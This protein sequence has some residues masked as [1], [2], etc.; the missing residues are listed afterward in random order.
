M[1]KILFVIG[2]VLLLVVG[3]LFFGCG[4]YYKTN[5]VINNSD[6]EVTFTFSRF[7]ETSYTL[8]PHTSDYYSTKPFIKTYSAKPPRVSYTTD[9]DNETVT[10]Y[11]TTA[12]PIKISNDLDR[13]ILVTAQGC[14]DNEPITVLA[15]DEFTGI[16]YTNKPEFSG[17][18]V[19]DRFPISFSTNGSS[20]IAHW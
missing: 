12:K 1:R 19:V 7:P 11:N 17:F 20:V 16:I 2:I 15:N 18:T 10:F 6:Y 8:K 9:S 5:Q 14:M 13:D 3:G 4:D